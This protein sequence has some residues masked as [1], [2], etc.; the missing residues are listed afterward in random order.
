MPIADFKTKNKSTFKRTE[1][2]SLPIGHHT[3]RILSEKATMHD[4]HYVNNLTLKCLGED[5]PICANNKKMFMEF[6]REAWKQKGFVSMRPMGY[7]N[8]LDRTPVK[9]CPNTECQ[10]EV[11]KVGNRFP[12]TCPKCN[13]SLLTVQASPLNKVKVLSKGKKFFD[14]VEFHDAST[15]DEATETPIG[16]LNYDLDILVIDKNTAPTVSPRPD[17]NDVV[18]VPEEALFDLETS[19]VSLTSD[20]MREVLRGTRLADIFVARKA[21]APTNVASEISNSIDGIFEN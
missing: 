2:I 12:D 7:L 3:I 21:S 20:E 10:E 5:C 17:K 14:Q 15:L 13:A 18:V 19:I 11:K 4:T 16:I 6:G 1:F 8:V 9:I